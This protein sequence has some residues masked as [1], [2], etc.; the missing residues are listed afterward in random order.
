MHSSG[1]GV[2]V[3]EDRFLI[4]GFAFDLDGTI[5]LGNEILPG[6]VELLAHLRERGI[7][8]VFATNNSSKTAAEYIDVL[9]TMGIPADLHQVVTSNDVAAQHLTGLGFK[10]AYILATPAVTAEYASRGLTHA[11]KRPEAVLLTYDTSLTYT[12][13]SEANTL[14]VGGLPFFATHPDVVCPTPAGPLP[15]CGS[16]AALFQ[17]SSGRSPTVLGKPTLAMADAIRKRLALKRGRRVAFVGDRLYTDIRMA[18]EHDFAAI[19]TL[20]GEADTMALEDSTYAADLVVNSLSELL[21][22]LIARE[23]ALGVRS[24]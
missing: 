1:T 5:Y 14:L 2:L 23:D 20:S 18:N 12:K 9:S 15:D 17:A 10:R 13:V 4:G 8:H 11:V 3:D 19:L 7:P 21:E 24:S 22:W 6:A 16:F